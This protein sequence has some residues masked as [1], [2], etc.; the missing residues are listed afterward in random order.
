MLRSLTIPTL[1]ISFTL[2]TTFYSCT[3][4]PV[5]DDAVD[6]D[7]DDQDANESTSKSLSVD[8]RVFSVPSPAQTALML[9]SLGKGYDKELVVDPS[10]LEKMT[11]KGEKALMMGV[12]GADLAYAVAF[13]DG[14][15]GLK[16]FQAV[17]RVAVD[18][19][20]SNAIDKTLVERFMGNMQN[21]DSLLVLSGAAFSAADQ[22]L[23]ENDRNDISSLVLAG[24]WLETLNTSLSVYSKDPDDALALRI[25]EQRSALNNLVAIVESSSGNEKVNGF[26]QGLN[27]LNSMFQSIPMEYQYEK[28]T[29]DIANKTTFI[30]STTTVDLE[31]DVLEKITAKVKELRQL[32]TS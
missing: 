4:E 19:S 2:L 15:T 30:N 25:A 29:T 3:E 23:K 16:M 9:K 7:V 24:G 17:E 27:E 5:V 1:L 12:F 31:G 26:I 21:D 22:Y 32:I 28:P 14:Q 18:L 8:G 10:L 20:L 6:M 13:Q 11:S